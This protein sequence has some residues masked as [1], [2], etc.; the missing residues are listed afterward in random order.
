MAIYS[1]KYNI[2][3]S[4][5]P[6]TASTA[7]QEHLINQYDGISLKILEETLDSDGGGWGNKHL[8]FTKILNSNF[9][10]EEVFDQL[11]KI[12]TIRNPFDVF[13]SHWLNKI[14]HLNQHSWSKANKEEELLIEDFNKWIEY[15]Y[16]IYLYFLKNSVAHYMYVPVNEKMDINSYDETKD[17]FKEINFLI[18][19]NAYYSK[20]S[21]FCFRYENLNED[22]KN[23]CETF[24]I[25]Y[26]EIPKIN[27]TKDKKNYREY[28]SDKTKN[29][30]TEICKEELEKF[31]YEF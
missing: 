20:Y 18:C 16:K 8:N 30:I 11:I 21:N 7:M 2:L 3:Y 4:C 26:L 31:N 1:E 6:R 17:S 29:M 25:K 12:T 19:K 28:Y 24:G 27:V 23:F 9:F 10:E 22:F 13:V 14:K 5:N 15:K